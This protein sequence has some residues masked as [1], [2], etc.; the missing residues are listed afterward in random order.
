MNDS[1]SEGGHG[2]NHEFRDRNAALIVV[3]VIEILLGLGCALLVP[4]SLLAIS[5]TGGWGSGRCPS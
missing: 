5:V 1:I 3:S 2:A 4:L